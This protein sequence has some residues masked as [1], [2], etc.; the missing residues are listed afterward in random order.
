MGMLSFSQVLIALEND[1]LLY[2]FL[3]SPGIVF[4]STAALSGND[5]E[6]FFAQLFCKH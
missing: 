2:N 1:F 5:L 4:H 6:L 3:K